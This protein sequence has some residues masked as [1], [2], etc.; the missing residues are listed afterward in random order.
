MEHLETARHA[1]YVPNSLFNKQKWKGS[2]RL[3][4]SRPLSGGGEEEDR[5]PDLCIANAALS[6]LSYPPARGVKLCLSP[7]YLA[8]E[9]IQSSRICGISQLR[10]VLWAFSKELFRLPTSQIQQ[11]LAP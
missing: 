9:L 4:T 1:L 5:T 7:K 11:L 2:E 6:Q 3:E 8:R 10:S